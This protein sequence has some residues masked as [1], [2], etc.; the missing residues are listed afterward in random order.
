MQEAT[1]EELMIAYQAGDERAFELLYSRYSE[2]LYSYLKRRL[3]NKDW[4]D[5]VFQMVFTKLHRTRHQYDPVH[6]FDQWVFV[7]TKTVLLD[8]WKTTDL[9]TKRYFATSID[10][11]PESSLPTVQPAF[12][13]AS[14][15]S[16]SS[17][18]ALS[19]EQKSAV[20]LK[21]I[22]DLSYREIAKKLNRSEENVRQLVSRALKK[23][24]SLTTTRGGEK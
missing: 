9:K 23:I 19:P 22:D 4:V 16:L 8:F 20:E 21:F 17:L 6:R 10:Q 13:V 18:T 7:M 5:D 11:V 2:R 1:D 12:E 3:E 14:S 15:L 24:Q